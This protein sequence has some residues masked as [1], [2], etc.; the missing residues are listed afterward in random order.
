MRA[1][2]GHGERLVRGPVIEDVDEPRV[3]CEKP[4]GVT[5]SWRHAFVGCAGCQ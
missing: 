1:S 2:D 3:T 4:R 5:D